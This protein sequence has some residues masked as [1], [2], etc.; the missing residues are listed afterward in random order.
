MKKII[1]SVGIY[2]GSNILNAL[3]PFILLPILTRYLDVEEYGEVAI[4]LSLVGIFSALV[5]TTMIGSVS[6]KYFDAGQTPDS[7]AEYVS[8]AIQLIIF[9]TISVCSIF[10]VISS[11]VA[12]SLAINESFL[13]IALFV[14]FSS[15]I[16]QIK[17]NQYQIRKEA[18]KYGS[19]QI[20]RSATNAILSLLGVIA[21]GLGVYGRIGGQLVSALFFLIIALVLLYRDHQVK[22]TYHIST[23]NYMEL[24]LFAIPL[25]PHVL[26]GFLLNTIDRVIVGQQLGL[27]AAGLYAVAFQIAAAS[28]FIFDAVNKATQPWLFESLSK[29][30]RMINLRIV[31]LTYLWFFLLFLGLGLFYIIGPEL[32]VFIAGNKYQKAGELVVILVAAQVFKGMYLAVVNYCFYQKRTGYLS[33]ISIFVG[34]IN[35]SLI[36]VLIP[37]F[38]LIGVA[39]SYLVSSVMRFFMVWMLANKMHPMPWTDIK[40]FKV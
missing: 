32:L 26:G 20:S 38:G 27:A 5:G 31:R 11:Y 3:I 1:S 34:G 40:I 9:F 16:V 13:F 23:K 8:S 37:L 18:L 33:S 2:F 39:Y 21:F 14:A 15:T 25:I 6:R 28:G 36:L 30:D 19:L 35:I 17:L 29:Q 12:S 4:F 7:Y 10:L 24:L 22:N